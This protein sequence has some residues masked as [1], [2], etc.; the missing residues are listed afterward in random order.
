MDGF[1]LSMIMT[2]NRMMQLSTNTS[3][4]VA[5]VNAS[6]SDIIE[7][8][9]DGL[10]VRRSPSVPAAVT[11]V[12]QRKSNIKKTSVVVERF[13]DSA[14]LDAMERF[15]STYGTV[16]D[17]ERRI[18]VYS[19]VGRGVDFVDLVIYLDEDS[20]SNIAKLKYSTLKPMDIYVH[21]RNSFVGSC[22]EF[23]FKKR[24]LGHRRDVVKPLR[25]EPFGPYHCHC[26]PSVARPRPTTPAVG[27][28]TWQEHFCCKNT[29]CYR[30]ITKT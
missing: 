16:A 13:P 20:V 26:P 17:I 18:P 29:L 6:E 15:F 4:I 12:A 2:F 5:A 30:T 23:F 14:E 24:V 7:I 3:V 27:S 1:A 8:S 21:Y 10:Y 25:K 9:S 28:G 19:N 22:V 11:D